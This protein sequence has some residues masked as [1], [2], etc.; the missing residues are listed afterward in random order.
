MYW[1][2]KPR[3]FKEWHRSTVGAEELE[4]LLLFNMLP[5]KLPTRKLVGVYAKSSCWATIKVMLVSFN[6]G[7]YFLFLTNTL[8]F[9]V[10]LMDHDVP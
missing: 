9:F 8:L 4:I 7:R 6:V 10:E 1:T 5:R 3:D 2:K